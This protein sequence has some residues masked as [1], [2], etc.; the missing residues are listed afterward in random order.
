MCTQQETS[1]V[2][3]FDEGCVS[4]RPLY[5][6][7]KE[8]ILQHG[9]SLGNQIR[10]CSIG[11]GIVGNL[12]PGVKG[13]LL[14]DVV[15]VTLDRVGGNMKPMADLLIAQSVADQADDL[16]FP[17]GHPN[18]LV[19]ILPTPVYGMLDDLGK[20]RSVQDGGKHLFSVRDR[21]DRG[22]KIVERRGFE[23]ESRGSGLDELQ[24]VAL[25][26]GKIHYDHL[27]VGKFLL[28]DFHHMEAALASQTQIQRY[29]IRL[30][31]VNLEDAV[32]AVSG[33]GDNFDVPVALQHRRNTVPKEAVV[34]DQKQSD[35]IH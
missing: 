33:C 25:S 17:L 34:I 26:R 21:T 7:G 19:E 11:V 13:K 27:G 16:P 22:E 23:D 4:S 20:E 2:G 9:K 29:H 1:R 14:H 10:E 12:Q 30:Q 18:G 35:L 15:D 5:H 28:H 32:L 24:D 6:S 3:Q 8:L 31:F